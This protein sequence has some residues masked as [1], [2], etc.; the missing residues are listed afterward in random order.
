M[1][2]KI[3][4]DPPWEK[5]RSNRKFEYMVAPMPLPFYTHEESEIIGLNLYGQSGWELIA[6]YNSKAYFRR[7][8]VMRKKEIHHG[9][10]TR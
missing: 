2:I 8:Y 1:E 6:I 5:V 10:E 4:V 9:R 7:A 3:K